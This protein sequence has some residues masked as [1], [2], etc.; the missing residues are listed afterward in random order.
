MT[1]KRQEGLEISR[2]VEVQA[3][4]DLQVHDLS[5]QG[6]VLEPTTSAELLLFISISSYYSLQLDKGPID[7]F[8]ALDS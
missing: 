7:I 1:F 2:M 8:C 6:Q 5:V 3:R 4:H